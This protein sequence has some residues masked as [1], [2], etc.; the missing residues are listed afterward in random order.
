LTNTFKILLKVFV[1]V[2]TVTMSNKNAHDYGFDGNATATDRNLLLFPSLTWMFV[3]LTRMSIYIRELYHRGNAEEFCTICIWILYW[4]PPV[5]IYYWMCTGVLQYKFPIWILYWSPPVQ[6]LY[7][8][9]TGVLRYKFC[10]GFVLES[11]STNFRFEFCTG[12]LRYKFCTGFVLESSSTNFRFEFCTGFCTG[13]IR[14]LVSAIGTTSNSLSKT[15]T[16]DKFSKLL[17]MSM[18]VYKNWPKKRFFFLRFSYAS[19]V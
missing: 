7:W 2:G 15:N 11:S 16:A 3:P 12:V 5:Q 10:T 1:N 4:S 9:C 8:I 18:S 17:S 13:A 6:I 19:G 14:I